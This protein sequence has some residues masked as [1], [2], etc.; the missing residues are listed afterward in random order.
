MR[1]SKD[2]E[3]I[4]DEP[5]Q[6]RES[7]RIN[8]SRGVGFQRRHARKPQYSSPPPLSLKET[9]ITQGRLQSCYIELPSSC[10]RF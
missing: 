10:I 4:E 1:I 8:Y 6:Q 9:P 7:E 2:G 3:K 5:V